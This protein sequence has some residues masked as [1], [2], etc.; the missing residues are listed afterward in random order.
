[1]K[2]KKSLFLYLIPLLIL[3]CVV[4]QFV[5]YFFKIKTES[6]YYSPEIL[7]VLFSTA[8]IIVILIVL[9]IKEKNFD[10]VGMAF[11][12]ITSVK[13]VFSY[14]ILRPILSKTMAP[15]GIEKTNFFVMFVVFLAIETV[16]TIRILNEKHKNTN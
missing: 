16:V 12:V 8:S 5:F 14:V 9:K 11:L 13:M 7:Y 4:H 15:N 6:F 1:M 3:T 10:S 2:D